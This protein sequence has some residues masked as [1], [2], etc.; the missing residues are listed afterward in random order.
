[1]V[2]KKIITK[3]FLSKKNKKSRK[4][5]NKKSNKKSKNKRGGQ[6]HK[7]DT[8]LSIRSAVKI[9]RRYYSHKFE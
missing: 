8:S 4:K 6:L 3:K 1:M 2:K 7:N 5:S 9:L